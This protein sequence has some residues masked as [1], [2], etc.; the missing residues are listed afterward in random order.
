MSLTLV[1]GRASEIATDDV[2]RLRSGQFVMP[3]PRTYRLP[4]ARSHSPRWMLPTSS[5][6]IA[7][8]WLK[9]PSMTPTIAELHAAQ[10]SMTA[11]DSPSLPARCTQRTEY[12]APS[13]STSLPVPSGELSS[14]MTISPRMPALEKTSVRL[15]MSL[16]I[17][18]ASLYVGITTETSNAADTWHLLLSHVAVDLSL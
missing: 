13:S 18:P 16:S 6:M 7:G 9:S 8:S 3:P 1:S 11:D 10:P 17:P 2:M 12:F 14:T 15:A 5:G 4:I